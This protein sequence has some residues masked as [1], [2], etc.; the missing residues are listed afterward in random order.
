MYRL[1]NASETQMKKWLTVYR[2][3]VPGARTGQEATPTATPTVIVPPPFLERPYATAT[4][5]T[6]RA[7]GYP[8]NSFFDHCYPI[9]EAEPA[10]EVQR[11]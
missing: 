9:Y 7:F 5:S 2:Q 10:E 6:P 8:L 1:F 11:G 4:P 3:L